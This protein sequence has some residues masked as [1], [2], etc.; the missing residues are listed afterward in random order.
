M[1][2]EIRRKKNKVEYGDEDAILNRVVKEGHFDE[3]MK[4]E[5]KIE[6]E[7][8]LCGLGG[9]KSIPGRQNRKGKV[10]NTQYFWYMG[11]SDRRPVW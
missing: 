6:Q 9:R 7:F 1:P 11:G 3:D 5:M 2:G 8:K 10:S 4:A